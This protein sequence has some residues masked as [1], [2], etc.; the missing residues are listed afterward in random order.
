MIEASY[1]SPLLRGV[2]QLFLQVFIVLGMRQPY[3]QA[4]QSL[5]D[6]L[7]EREIEL[8]SLLADG[9]TNQQIAER[10]GLTLYTVKWYLKQ[11]YSKL[12]VGNRTQAAKKAVKMMTDII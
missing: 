4:Q 6:E 1:P 5:L 8:T 10:T 2:V 12:Q 7:T 11:I 9:L 3:M